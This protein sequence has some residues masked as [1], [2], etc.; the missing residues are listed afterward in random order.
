MTVTN[1]IYSKINMQGQ[2]QAAGTETM[3]KI[4][5]YGMPL[6]FLFWFN[7]YCAGLSYYYFLSLLITILQT[8]AIRHW[9]IDEDKVRAEMAANAKKPRKKSGWMARLEEAQRQQQA[10]L[11]QQQQQ[12]KGGKGKR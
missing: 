4:M 6:L 11:R 9:A 5:T 1:I 8:W 10:L 12:Q 3:M 2:A 7:N